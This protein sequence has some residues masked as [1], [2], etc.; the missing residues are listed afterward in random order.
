MQLYC[1]DHSFPQAC[2]SCGDRMFRMYVFAETVQKA[3][4]A[5]DAVCVDCVVVTK[6]TIPQIIHILH[7]WYG[8]D[9]DKTLAHADDPTDIMQIG[10]PIPE[11]VE[12]LK[13][14]LREGKN[15]KIFTARVAMTSAYS[16]VSQRFDDPSFVQE[17][18]KLIHDWCAKHI[19][20]I[21]PVTAVKDFACIEIFDDRAKQVV[22]NTG[23]LVED[24]WAKDIGS[25]GSFIADAIQNGQALGND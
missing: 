10:E 16:S 19:G 4:T 13:Q 11:M 23:E 18:I 9:I 5:E 15:V 3:A 1:L 22:P 17:Q 20:C 21:L 2:P 7:G 24:R 25:F 6:E 8:F 12:R 14:M